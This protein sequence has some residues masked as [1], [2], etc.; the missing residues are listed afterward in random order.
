MPQS[1]LYY[2]TI[3][4][5]D[6]T[7]LRNAVLYWDTISSIVP[8]GNYDDFSP[9]VQYLAEQEIYEPIFPQELFFSEHAEDFANTVI[10][11]LKPYVGGIRMNRKRGFAVPPMR[12]HRKKIY[13]P[14]LR[15]L[16]HYRKIPPNLLSYF[17]RN[18]LIN[19]ASRGDWLEMDERAALIYMRTL[20]EFSVRHLGDDMVVGTD[21]VSAQR[22]L[23]YKQWRP[24]QVCISL[25]LDHCLPRPAPD[26]SLE[27]LVAFKQEH[28]LELQELWQKIRDFELQLAHCESMD[29]VQLHAA[30]F[31][32]SWEIELQEFSR[33]VRRERTAFVL[34]SLTSLIEVPVVAD[35][36]VQAMQTPPLAA[37]PMLGGLASINIGQKFVEYRNKINERRSSAGFAYIIR[38]QRAGIIEF[39]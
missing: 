7:W 30:Q 33:M 4:I 10:Q 20:A 9:E 1:I 19:V 17:E 23:Y 32:E 31:R 39:P 8:Y 28:R 24:N 14:G 2:P 27:D 3:D 26:V 11:R 25:L 35:F 13:A 38:G 22:E 21:K 12:I 34:G 29:E 18:H 37:I 16:I 15:E 36:F 5:Q 6:G